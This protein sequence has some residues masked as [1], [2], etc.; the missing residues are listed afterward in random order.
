MKYI[1]C[2]EEYKE[3]K[4]TLFLAG[5]ITGCN[6]WQKKVVKEL[7]NE[8]LVLFNPRRNNFVLDKFS[9]EIQIKWE[10]KYLLRAD[11]ILF[12]FPC[13]TLCPITLYE[14]GKMLMT[15]KRIFLGIHPKYK[16]KRDIEIQTKLIRP[17]IEIVYSISDLID[18]VMFWRRS[19]TF[20]LGVKL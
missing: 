11:A 16:R 14:L 13:E 6:D 1:E 18:Q 20:D 2:P 19:K 7:S 17:E 5:G 12:W 10:H 4:R 8:D 9:S 3:Y 15:N